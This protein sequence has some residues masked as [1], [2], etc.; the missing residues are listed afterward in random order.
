M[1]NRR[2]LAA[3]AAAALAL[4]LYGPAGAEENECPEGYAMAEDLSCVPED[5]WDEPA[6]P[7][8]AGPS[9]VLAEPE[10]TG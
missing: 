6:E 10:Y 7:V 5:F 1:R 3:A 4:G 9:P 8:A 2:K